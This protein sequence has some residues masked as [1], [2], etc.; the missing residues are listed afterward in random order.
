MLLAITDLPTG[1]SVD[2]TPQTA[3]V[4]CYT[5]PLAR[6]PSTA[7]AHVSF[8]QGGGTPILAEELG[9]YSSGPSA[10]TKITGTLNGC[11]TFTETNKGETVNGVMG[12][13]SSPN[14]GDQSAAYDATLTIQGTS[15]NQGF[16]MVRKGNFI[17]LVALGDIGSLD[18]TKL[19]QFV[20]Q[21]V[22]KVAG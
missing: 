12:P 22:T 11:K 16:V 18:A 5:N 10:F 8:A 1:W 19:Q 15:V 17:T 21:A 9:F 4:S 14:Y 3:S 20:N 7:Y 6:V 13:M 2:N